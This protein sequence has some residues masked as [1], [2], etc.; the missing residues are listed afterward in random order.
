MTP[1]VTGTDETATLATLRRLI[2]TG[3]TAQQDARESSE[4]DRDY[5]DGHQLTDVELA[6]LARRRQP[7]IVINRIRRKVDAMVGIEQRGRVDPRAYPRE[8]GDE[9]AAE[10]ATKALLYVEQRERLDVLR[11]AAFENLLVE[12]YGGVEVGAAEVNGVVDVKVTR[13]RWEEI[14]FDPYSREKDFSD[15]SW[16]GVMKWM[17]VDAAR[18][19]ARAYTDDPAVIEGMADF[20][21][22]PFTGTSLADRPKDGAFTWADKAQ[23]RVRVSQIYRRVG[24]VWRLYVFTGRAL[25]YDA[26]SPYK[27]ENDQPACAILLMS[28]YVDRENRRYGLVRDMIS[29]QDEINKRRSKM[30]HNLNSRQ[31]IGVKGAVD[32]V[33]TLKREMADANGHVEL[34][35]DAIEDAARVGMKPFDFI[36]QGDQTS[37]QAM[38]LQE[39]K[40]EIDMLGPN[41][42]LV[43]QGAS[44]ASGR[45][46]MAQ[47]QAGLAE[48]AP[49]Y[50]GLRDWTERVYRAVWARVRQ[51]WD[52]PRW[53]RV[54]E[55]D[56]APQFLGINQ[57]AMDPMSGLPV[58]MNQVGAIDV[59]I[60][61]DQAP[62]Y[63]TLRAEQFETLANLAQSG[64]PIPPQL[65]VEASD[66]RDK[67][68][69]LAM[70]QPPE[71]EAPPPVDPVVQQLALR[72]AVAEVGAKEAR[73]ERDR[74]AAAK[75]MATLPK[76][77]AEGVGAQAEAQE[78]ALRARAM[79]ARAAAEQAEA[80]IAHLAA[81]RQ[82]HLLARPTGF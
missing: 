24:G 18:D 38:L 67:R 44:S 68:K 73:A 21:A 50:D 16:I 70:L 29:P 71:P 20:T 9:D 61:V 31:T 27:D 8:P 62:E 66:L 3:A 34:N 25:L 74:A 32:S 81:Q 46:I 54:T 76:V 23:R 17:A 36:P 60:I 69:L 79:E 2:E 78:A 41:P 51:T 49:I 35:A 58:V 57:P 22:D 59:D 82:A 33:A 6:V 13:L 10:L 26:P 37:G 52:G 45:A 1:A 19:F 4:R 5:Y 77:Q 48:L 12:G 43:G 40:A 80:M 64:V 11:S 63:A 53:I 65:I 14:V 15:A 55:Q 28:A 39:S 56:E 7:P 30:L 42:A 75:D 72:D 47:Q